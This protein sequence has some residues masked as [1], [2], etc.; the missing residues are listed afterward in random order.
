MNPIT[1]LVD[2]VVNLL[3]VIHNVLA[4]LLPA[5]E[6]VVLTVSGELPER[7]PA[8]VSR[9]RRL[10]PPP[11]APA[12]QESLEEW[13]ERLQLLAR[14]P[15]VR[16]VV[17]KF[18]DLR[19]GPAALESLRRALLVF[20]ERG[21][22]VVAYLPVADLFWYYL[23]SAAEMIVVPESA[24]IGLMGPRSE[25]T[26][27]RVALDR[28]GIFPQYHHI[29]EYKTAAHRLL[30]PEMPEAQ[31][32]MANALLDG[33]YGEV[34]ATVARD[35]RLTEETVRDAVD[36]GMLTAAEGKTR[37]LIDGVA[38]EDQLPRILG[39]EH[40]ARLVPWGQARA[41][42]RVPYRWHGWQAQAVGVI[43][44]IGA[45]VPGESRDLPVPVPLFGQHLAGDE[46]VA[47]AFRLAERMPAV[48]ALIFHVDSGGGSAVASDLIWREVIR[49]QQH[50][51]VVVYMSNVAGSGGYYVACGARHIVA[52]ATTITGSI[53][54][55]AGKVNVQGLY[56]KLGL[57]REVLARGATGAMNS[58]FT[59]FT[60]R[61]WALLRQWM[62]DIYLRFKSKVASGRGQDI[63]R[64]ES[65]ARG[66][67][68]TG[69]QA[70]DAGLID[71]I[72]DF[73]AAVRTARS[74][75]GI[76]EDAEVPVVTIRPPKVTAIPDGS[77]AA[78][79]DGL[80]RVARLLQEPTLLIMPEE[81][82]PVG[83]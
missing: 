27:L 9:L 46:T 52:A 76:R 59:P 71:E 3:R 72:G 41:R 15:R 78:W 58:A 63:E 20:R 19:A 53:G 31:R 60:D 25:A 48:K 6:Y 37:G 29:A 82:R 11:I 80:R 66:R 40:P 77:V 49:L 22:R 81:M 57:H 36:Q 54:V 4:T 68:Y 50:K 73:A 24:E 2:A 12:P 18:L 75:A 8:P 26:F 43:E 21:K 14:E 1:L 65:L 47:R 62:A 7:R 13:R 74:L 32:E 35:R 38:F 42:V 10:I 70:R 67:V 17:L 5:P 23:A 61:E 33:L 79:M 51:P 45:I 64:V 44:L 56:A 69:R 28:L 30:Y 83:V 34:V 55:V 16:G 39:D